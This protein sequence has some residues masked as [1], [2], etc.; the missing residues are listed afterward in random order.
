MTTPIILFCIYT[1]RIPVTVRDEPHGPSF[2]QQRGHIDRLDSV[3]IR[4]IKKN[5]IKRART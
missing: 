2:L 5:R 1:H 3:S 4:V